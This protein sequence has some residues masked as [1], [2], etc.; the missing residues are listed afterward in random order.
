M[1][2]HDWPELIDLETG[3]SRRVATPAG[4][5][6]LKLLAVR[7][8]YCPDGW[9]R[10][11]ASRRTL[12]AAEVEVE[13]DGERATLRH[14]PYEMPAVVG[15]LRLYVEAASESAGGIQPIADLAGEV[16]LSA[17]PAD[18]P[19]G[20]TDL[21]F[22][23]R[24]Y[25][26]RATPYNNTWGALVPYNLLY[27]HRGEDY[28]L[29]PNRTAVLSTTA[30][31]VTNAPGPRPVASNQVRVARPDGVAVMHAHMDHEDI[32]PAVRR[33]ARVEAGQPLGRSGQTWQGRRSQHHDPHLHVG[34]ALGATPLGSYP[35]LVEAYLRD[36]DDP[37]LPNAGGYYFAW[38]GETIALDATAS[39]ARP[40][41]SIVGYEWHLHDGAV[42]A[43]ATLERR[44]AHPGQFIEELRLTTAGGM[45]LRD[46][47]HVRVY[48]PALPDRPGRA[49]AYH[50]PL[51]DIAP[52]D[53]V[54]F[55]SRFSAAD[56][57]TIDYGDGSPA[58]PIDNEARHAYA[59]PGLYTVTLQ[60]RGATGQ[61]VMQKLC[62]TVGA[63]PM[64]AAG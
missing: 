42:A 29:I 34:F 43:G 37:A 39:L 11:N 19:W 36:Y 21:R 32:D 13:V 56:A 52:G 44:Y 6:R 12:A 54:L 2:M 22:P 57:V 38:A 50:H 48:D 31:V 40:G 64:D 7:P 8:R 20:P 61:P 15:G 24:G 28:G 5:H 63:A 10:D 58:E 35:L 55:W 45:E 41:E 62:V 17:R 23:L 51:R 9:L 18:A 1:M 25:R 53:E 33:H 47:A 26:W 3:E 14:R 59:A 49:W 30:G 4:T 46:F 60:G 16:R 27:Y